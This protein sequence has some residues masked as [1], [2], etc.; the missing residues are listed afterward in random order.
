MNSD[1][2]RDAYGDLPGAPWDIEEAEKYVL[3]CSFIQSAIAAYSARLTRSSNGADRQSMLNCQHYYARRMKELDPL[4]KYDID[5]ILKRYPDM[6]KGIR[7]ET[8]YLFPAD[9]FSPYSRDKL[10]TN[11][12]DEEAKK[13]EEAGILKESWETRK[14][15]ENANLTFAE[16]IRTINVDKSSLKNRD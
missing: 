2:L 5:H 4:D 13:L 9:K 6:I 12:T 7:E 14:A 16:R 11:V 15:R 10:I 3:A 1:E 8:E